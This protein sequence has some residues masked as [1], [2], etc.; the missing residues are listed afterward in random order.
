MI[1]HINIKRLA[2]FTFVLVGAC[3][4]ST[5]P[6]E[7]FGSPSSTLSID[8]G[9]EVLITMRT[10]GPGEYASPPVVTGTAV[11][12]L[13]VSLADAQVPAGETQVFRFKGVSRGQAVVV[14]HNTGTHAD[15]S[16]TVVVR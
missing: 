8:V 4:D 16:D 10:V 13:D 6:L 5:S 2:W 1:T 7:V 9:Q 12:F 3:A 11:T 15:V 14:F